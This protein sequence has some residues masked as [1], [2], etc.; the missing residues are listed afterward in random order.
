MLEEHISDAGGQDVETVGGNA[1]RSGSTQGAAKA[2]PYLLM[3][4]RFRPQVSPS[5]RL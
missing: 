4:E 2:A 5:A 3:R 1:L